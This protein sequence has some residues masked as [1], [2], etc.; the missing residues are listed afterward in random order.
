M[1]GEVSARLATAV[2][3]ILLTLVSKPS[4]MTSGTGS[5]GESSKAYGPK[6]PP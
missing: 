4:Q 6:K 3:A 2:S 1:S 5:L